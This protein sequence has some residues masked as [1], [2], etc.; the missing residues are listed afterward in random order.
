MEKRGQSKNRRKARTKT[1][2]TKKTSGLG[3]TNSGQENQRNRGYEED[4]PGNPLRAS[5]KTPADQMG[6]NYTPDTYDN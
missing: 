5:K 2:W 4:Q 1:Y 3:K 6:R